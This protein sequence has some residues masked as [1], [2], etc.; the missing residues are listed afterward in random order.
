MF[1][2]TRILIFLACL[3]GE[4]V[5]NESALIVERISGIMIARGNYNLAV[6]L[7]LNELFHYE[8][9]YQGVVN[10]FSLICGNMT[11]QIPKDAC[12]DLFR[13]IMVT[14]GDVKGNSKTI[15]NFFLHRSK[16]SVWRSLGAMDKADRKRIDYDLYKLRRNQESLRSLS[17][18]QTAMVSALYDFVNNSMI[19]LDKNGL[20]LVDKV[21]DLQI[22]VIE[23]MNFTNQV[24]KIVE[25]ETKLLEAGLWIQNFAEVIRKRQTI[26]MKLLMGEISKNDLLLHIISPDAILKELEKAIQVLPTGVKFP[27]EKGELTESMFKLMRLSH[28]FVGK[29]TLVLDIEIP[30]VDVNAYEALKIFITPQ[31][32]NFTVTFCH[33]ENNIILRNKMNDW[34]YVIDEESFKHC[35]ELQN[36]RMCSVKEPE[37]NLAVCNKCS[38]Q[39][40]YGTSSEA[41]N[42]KIVQVNHKM[43]FNSLQANIWTYISPM[44]IKVNVTDNEK[45]S[46]VTIQGVGKMTLRE[47]MTIITDELIIR[48]SKT[49]ISQGD[50]EIKN[51]FMNASE[52][53]F[54]DWQLSQL[55]LINKTEKIYSFLDN[56]RMFDLGI[57]IQDLKSERPML[58][59]LIYAPLEKPWWTSGIILGGVGILLAIFCGFKGKLSCCTQVLTPKSRQ[60]LRDDN[61]I[62]QKDIEM[63]I[64]NKII[65]LKSEKTAEKRE[66]STENIECMQ[67]NKTIKTTVK[68]KDQS[69]H[70]K[71]I[72]NTI[73]EKKRGLCA[74]E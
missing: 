44:S 1:Y 19:S 40:V 65:K 73:Q 27:W 16:R 70:K 34:G 8:H 59:N 21:K 53:K 62:K 45:S 11:E 63:S 22:R 68:K 13:T 36:I 46:I 2:L 56:K 51:N 41:C 47:G 7:D 64:L 26:F 48:H 43:W 33:E 60:D 25:W 42:C 18:H 50:I 37:E 6:S 12:Q 35:R 17:D 38:T 39:L 58:E 57:G 5:R 49:I 61:I 24:R 55:P 4:A 52:I 28:R 20:D 9:L 32:K 66:T 71:D 3:W 29:E 54:E 10:K 69:T 67:E 72:T 31:I 23:E 74:E 14:Q 30:L 15:Q